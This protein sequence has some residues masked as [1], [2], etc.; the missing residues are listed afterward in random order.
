MGL[1]WGLVFIFGFFV[2]VIWFRFLVRSSRF[3]ILEVAV[4][5]VFIV[6]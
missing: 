4:V 3:W 5:E 2:V 6:W 1:E